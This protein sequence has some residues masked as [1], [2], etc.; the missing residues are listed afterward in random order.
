MKK[1]VFIVSIIIFLLPTLPVMANEE[2][3]GQ[4]V[5]NIDEIEAQEEQ[6]FKIETADE[7]YEYASSQT[8]A[9]SLLNA[10]IDAYKAY[11][12]D[13]RFVNGLQDSAVNLLSW[14][15]GKHNQGE[16]TLAADRYQAI[17]EAP[18]LSSAFRTSVDQHVKY[19][20]EKKLVPTANDL[21]K[22]AMQQAFVSSIFTSFVDAYSW[23]PH[24]P[25]FQS[26]LQESAE[27]LFNW[28]KNK[29]N[30]SQY[31]LAAERYEL[32][33]S[34][35]D[36][37]EELKEEV[38]NQM[39]LA[40]NGTQSA[41]SLFT[42]AQK[43]TSASGKLDLFL[44]GYEL[45]PKDTRF[46]NGIQSSA[47]GLL[48]WARNQHNK[49][50]YA[51]AIDRYT[52][53]IRTPSINETI[54][55]ITEKHLAYAEARKAVP[56]A[57]SLYKKA[58]SLTTVSGIFE[59]YVEGLSWYPEDARFQK[60]LQSSAQSLF[61]W[62]KSKHDQGEYEKAIVRY[63]MILVES[64]ISSS[65]KK[66]VEAR[67]ADAKIGKRSANSI[68]QAA[69][70]DTT[71]SGKLNLYLEG[72]RFYPSDSRFK[73]GIKTSAEL[74]LKWT[75]TQHQKGS[76]DIARDRYSIILS[77]PEITSSFKYN[78]ELQQGFALNNKKIPSANEYYTLAMKEPTASGQLNAFLDGFLLHNDS[79][80][81]K[82]GINKSAQALLTWA[83]SK[84]EQKEYATA[85]NRYETLLAISP[86]A[87]G[88][89]QEASLKLKYA[90]N[91]EVFPT[92]N[93]LYKLADNH[94][95][96]SKQLETFIEGLIF[97]PKDTRF[98]EGLNTS[99]QS[100]L[101]WATTQHQKGNYETAK[102]RY[103][104]ILSTPEIKQSTIEETEFK[105]KYARKSQ[106]IPSANSLINQANSINTASG[107]HQLFILGN[108]IYPTDDRF[109]KGINSSSQLLLDWA[110]GQQQKRSYSVA[111][112]RYKTILNSPHLNKE[113]TER[114]KMQL[115]YA[116]NNKVLPD[117]MMIGT[118]ESDAVTFRTGPGSDYKKILNL[119]KN[120]YV[121]VLSRNNINWLKVSYD[122]AVGYVPSDSVKIKYI[123]TNPNVGPLN[124]QVII[125]DP[126]HGG[127][128]PGAIGINIIEKELVLDVSLRTKKLLE[129][130]GAIVIMTRSTDVFLE[131]Q[132]RAAIANSSN[133]DIFISVHANKFNKVTSGTETFWYGK[134][135]ALN[136]LDLAYSLQDAVVDKLNT[137]YRRVAEGNFH[138]IRETKIPSALL[139]LGFIDN[140]YDSSILSS[141]SNRQRAAE[142]MFNGI[143]N[144]FN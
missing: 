30:Q 95:S 105:L 13:S 94:S 43:E 58:T 46:L 60:G 124:G 12:N 90:E 57:D 141:S 136:S 110:T 11:P 120:T 68:Y 114:T 22:I 92:A 44:K 56:T 79:K 138:V 23:Y 4:K 39:K 74:L 127:K 87:E 80:K 49:G 27:S 67:L 50:N 18:N 101:R 53:I 54:K 77:V 48:S 36:I 130:A 40:A 108:V 1:L 35:P 82:E 69:I 126:G 51:T 31:D 16:F 115:Q 132:E 112:D 75:T 14:A 100:L 28:A 113:I 139:E 111:K 72:Y 32:I 26:G 71:A 135:Q 62:A 98:K 38:K 64:A 65:L 3:P 86:I 34:V 97:Y 41:D 129:D 109:I 47:D 96:A 93:E 63:D 2:G 122:G 103:G 128:D 6:Q 24:D 142:G 59:S 81:I 9:S 33:L 45:Y 52:R 19:A 17:L 61:D 89:K 99:A 106:K 83:S 55:K 88:I 84:H 121:E 140:F 118:I 78:V 91:K 70:K 133:A 102:D 131:L 10:Y 116:N 73:T 42:L 134:Y 29:H 20:H 7:W 117:P 85:I 25:R 137:R 125:L 123:S 144:Y 66:D 21:Y 104:R 107:K 8:S 143:K 37:D 119:S 76:F 5:T 15:R